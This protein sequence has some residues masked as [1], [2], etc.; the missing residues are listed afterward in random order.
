MVNEV[1]VVTSSIKKRSSV[2]KKEKGI[3]DSGDRKKIIPKSPNMLR[4]PAIR[5]RE[6]FFLLCIE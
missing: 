3:L 1:I 5:S 6:Y 2:G 4:M